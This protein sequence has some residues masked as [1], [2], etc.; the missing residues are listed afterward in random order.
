MDPPT[1]SR[2]A[3]SRE[4]PVGVLPIRRRDL[5]RNLSPA[6]EQRGGS[7]WSIP[8]FIITVVVVT[9]A[10]SEFRAT[11]WRLYL[12]F[13][14]LLNGVMPFVVEVLPGLG[15]CLPELA[16][17]LGF[18]YI[19]GAPIAALFLL[20]TIIVPPLVVRWSRARAR[21]FGRTGRFAD[22]R[23]KSVAEYGTEAATLVLGLVVR[24][25]VA[26]SIAGPNLP[27]THGWAIL[28]AEV[29][30]YA[31]WGLLSVLPFYPGR[32]RSSSLLP[33]S[34][35][36]DLFRSAIVDMSL[37]SALTLTPFI[38]LISYG[39]QAAGIA[40]AVAGSLSALA[41][42]FIL[43]RLIDRRRR[44]EDQNRSL[45]ELNRE[46]QQRERLSAIGKMSTIVSHQILQHL[47][48][49]GLHADLIRNA[50]GDADSV[51]ELAQ[52]R[53]NAAAIE[54]SLAGV[55]RVLQDLLIF[56]RDQR[57]NLY[58]HSLAAVLQECVRECEKEAAEQEVVI[59]IRVEGGVV[60]RFDKLKVVQA[61]V[62]LIRNAIQA[63][64]KNATV[65][66][67]GQVD[68]DEV[69]ISITD[70]GPG[71]PV[72]EREK[73]FTPFHSTKEQGTGLGLA[74][75]QIFAEAHGGRV[76]V[77]D[78][79]GG[80]GAVFTLQLPGAVSEVTPSL[81]TAAAGQ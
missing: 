64:P 80:D 76:I 38:F 31:T 33:L 66:L 39:Y 12:A 19:G 29:S 8:L 32:G 48:V 13:L 30:G 5:E 73:I 56:S 21:R 75:A 46:L 7:A 71:V 25:L 59:E 26:S 53:D 47:G 81:E 6:G 34:T 10:A 23:D 18:L 4:M 61:V 51:A 27:L 14:L 79:S 35:P 11:D 36:L 72:A 54:E 70:Q 55:N 60:A 65:V 45:E 52:A 50:E 78:A 20:N 24:W 1:R 43:K 40:G 67:A 42:H 28:A 68:C 57:V 37:V 2:I 49:I 44:L 16:A 69:R 74:I 63:S 17:T 62:N 77:E 3:R 9:G 22:W 15:L 58:E 41:P